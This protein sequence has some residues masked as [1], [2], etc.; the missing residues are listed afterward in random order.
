M[1]FSE[2]HTFISVNGEYVFYLLFVCMA[3]R[4]EFDQIK[5]EQQQ[6]AAHNYYVV[7]K[8]QAELEAPLKRIQRFTVKIVYS[9]YIC[10]T[11]TYECAKEES[12]LFNTHF[13]FLRFLFCT[14]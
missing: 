2:T 4:I 11:N 10:Y 3:N 1:F 5:G 14:N 6:P 8:I 7:G 13:F 9:V 12:I